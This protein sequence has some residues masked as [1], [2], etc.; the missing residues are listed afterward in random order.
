MSNFKIGIIAFFSI[1]SLCA[2]SFFL[3]YFGLVSYRFFAPR[4]AEAERKVFENTKSFRQGNI[5]ELRNYQISYIKADKDQKKMLASVISHQ[6]A[7]F[8]RDDLPSDL[9]VFLSEIEMKRLE[10]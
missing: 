8:N 7:D 9:K 3:E 1:L 10:P 2:L 6:F 5:Q 4:R